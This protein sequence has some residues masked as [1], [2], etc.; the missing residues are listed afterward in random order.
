MYLYELRLETPRLTSLNAIDLRILPEADLVTSLPE[1]L[2][3]V[4]CIHLIL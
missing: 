4:L 3:V 1:S 2:Q